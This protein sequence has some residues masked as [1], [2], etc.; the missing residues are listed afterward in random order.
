MLL[1]LEFV[2]EA[3]FF[4]LSLNKQISL[5]YLLAFVFLVRLFV[6]K[7]FFQNLGVKASC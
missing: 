2:F 3:H 1:L 4:P 7:S 6:A 5:C